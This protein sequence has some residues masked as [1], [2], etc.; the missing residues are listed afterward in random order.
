[1]TSPKQ[2]KINFMKTS[3][4][5]IVITDNTPEYQIHQMIVDTLSDTIVD[6]LSN[7]VSTTFEEDGIYDDTTSRLKDA[8]E[9]KQ[10][11]TR[12]KRNSEP[13]TITKPFNKH[14]KEPWLESTDLFDNHIN[15]IYG[16]KL[17]FTVTIEN[18]LV[19]LMEKC[20]QKL[21]S[22][23]YPDAIHEISYKIESK[24]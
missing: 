8:E 7:I 17:T 5:I 1:M 18:Y 4:D 6:D 9:L 10:A 3:I 19:P 20:L 22:H 16:K 2:R 23:G 13:Y 15:I 11:I 24:S 14:R 12:M 21:I